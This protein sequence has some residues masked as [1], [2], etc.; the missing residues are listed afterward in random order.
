MY[1]HKRYKGNFSRSIHLG[2]SAFV[3]GS[4]PARRYPQNEQKR[5]P[6]ENSSAIQ[7]LSHNSS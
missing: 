2:I 6:I 7:P 5:V 3:E 1:V 4:S